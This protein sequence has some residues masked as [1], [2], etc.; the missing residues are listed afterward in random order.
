MIIGIWNAVVGLLLALPSVS[1]LMLMLL[2]DPRESETS[3]P[4][5]MHHGMEVRL[6]LSKGPVY[7]S[8]V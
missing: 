8:I 2:A 1:L 7:P 6:G 5:D 4:V 3:L